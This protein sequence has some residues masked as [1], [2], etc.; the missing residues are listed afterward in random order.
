MK[1]KSSEKLRMHSGS[2]AKMRNR[3]TGAGP[4]LPGPGKELNMSM[5]KKMTPSRRRTKRYSSGTRNS[6]TLSGAAKSSAGKSA[7]AGPP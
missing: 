4:A 2:A 5:E 7:Y 6:L 1:E 3:N